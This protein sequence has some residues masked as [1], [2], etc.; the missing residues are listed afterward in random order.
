MNVW[1]PRRGKFTRGSAACTLRRTMNLSACSL[2]LLGAV[3]STMGACS[4]GAEGNA[5]GN[6]G[7]G[8]GG[9][10]TTTTV[11]GG[12]AGGGGGSGGSVMVSP[13]QKPECTNPDGGQGPTPEPRADTAGAL[14]ALGTVFLLFGGD[15]ATVI[16]GQTPKREHVGD[17]WL[18]DTACGGWTKLETPG[19][20]PRAR[21]SIAFDPASGR[22]LLFG[23]RYRMGNS[24]AYTN[25][26]DVWA[27]DFA[28][29]TWMEVVTTGTGPSARSNS[30]AAIVNGKL[31]VFGGNT[32]TSGLSFTPQN[33][34]FV[35]DLA[36]NVWAKVDVPGAKPEARLFHA[37]APHPTKDVV[38]VHSG[39]DE[40]AFLGPFF[41]D[42]WSLDLGANA[43]TLLTSVMP[44]GAGRIKHGLWATLIDGTEEAKVFAFGG[45]D[46]GAL[47][48]RNDLIAG[49]ANGAS[50]TFEEVRP[51]DTYKNAA[52]GACDF[53]VDFA[54]IDEA[55]P[56]RRSAF[57]IGALPDGSAAVVFGGDS[58]CGR[59]SD[60][61]WFDAKAGTWT[62]IR[63][64][65]PGLVCLRTGSTTCTSLCN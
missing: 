33:D 22:A 39:G 32:S 2:A 53:P 42:A 11:D 44:G 29:K 24:G 31:L 58:D 25:Y 65:L 56:E 16:C 17:T 55:S 21:H 52:N 37:M 8:G 14:N 61:H 3:L 60:A 41:T 19:P 59:L 48:N 30:A 49:V 64:T 13:S 6:G 12:G 45:H 46:D 10:A 38:F 34:V 1:L 36:T 28:A 47:G 7:D 63:A 57:A 4:P 50:W 40:N 5:G 54:T 43:W 35:L 26:N 9:G 15:V 18:L 27:F 51:G 20:S 23:G 62:E